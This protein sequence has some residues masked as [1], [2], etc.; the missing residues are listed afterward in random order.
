[1]EDLFAAAGENPPGT[2]LRNR[3]R[4]AGNR[5]SEKP[6]GR[7]ADNAAT[8]NQNRANTAGRDNA[9]GRADN[10]GRA[11]GAGR[12][13]SAQRGGTGGRAPDRDQTDNARRGNPTR[14][15]D[16]ARRAGDAGRD[17]PTRPAGNARRAD[18]AGWD[19]AAGSADG[20]GGMEDAEVLLA[21][22]ESGARGAV[23]HAGLER[24][25]AMV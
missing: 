20:G 14:R 3:A 17:N 22:L 12:A 23:C 19:Y 4:P 24:V 5:P 25:E 1:M 6:A 7:A 11:E 10:A 9:D 8:Q 16:N 21:G 18:A 13:E 15:A 2:P